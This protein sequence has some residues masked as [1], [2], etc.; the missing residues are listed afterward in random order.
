MI[1]RTNQRVAERIAAAPE[2]KTVRETLRSVLVEVLPLDEERREGT[3][4]WIAVL[5]RAALEPTLKSFM[6]DT[7]IN[8]HHNIAALMRAAQQRGEIPADRDPERETVSAMSL[9]DGL[10]SHILMG[11]YT[12]ET[13]LRAIDDYLDRL[14]GAESSGPA[15][16]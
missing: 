5:A 7:W 2:P 10:V 15:Q 1:E 14:F 9:T 6:R 12:D 16:I 8:G 4:V 11:H 3:R 13:A